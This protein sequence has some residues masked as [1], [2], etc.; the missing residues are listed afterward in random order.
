MAVELVTLDNFK[1]LFEHF[2]KT[3]YQAKKVDAITASI[4]EKCEKL[5]AKDY[6]FSIINN[7]NGE[8]CNTYPSRIIFLEGEKGNASDDSLKKPDDENNNINEAAR[9]RERV[10][11]SRV[12]RC[13]TRFPVPVILI[14]GKFICRSSTLACG[15]EIYPRM[16]YDYLFP[17]DTT[18]ADRENKNMVD[19][20]EEIEDS[21]VAADPIEIDQDPNDEE[22]KVGEYRTHDVLLLRELSI[23][24]ICDLMMEDRKVKLAMYVTSSEKADRRNRYKEFAVLSMPYPGCEFFQKFRENDYH[25]EKMKF[26]WSQSYIKRRL[27]LPCDYSAAVEIEWGKYKEWD[28]NTLTQNYMKVLIKCITEG[29]SS[30]LVHC[31]SGWDRTPLFISLLRMSLW[32]DG[33]VHHSLSPLEMV[34]LTVGYDWFLFGHQLGCRLSKREEIMKYCFYYLKP[35]ISLMNNEI[36]NGAKRPNSPMELEENPDVTLQSNNVIY[37]GS[38]GLK[39]PDALWS[40]IPEDHVMEHTLPQKNRPASSAEKQESALK[41]VDSSEDLSQIRCNTPTTPTHG[42]EDA[43]QFPVIPPDLQSTSPLAVP[44]GSRRRT[45]SSSSDLSYLFISETGSIPPTRSPPPE[46]NL[47]FRSEESRKD[48]LNEVRTIFLKMYFAFVD[49]RFKSGSGTGIMGF[50][51]QYAEKVGIRTPKP[52]T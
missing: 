4:Q 3:S 34:Y 22:S 1:E 24:R 49:V 30:L 43:A 40:P 52:P 42:K 14:D 45:E 23:T 36:S 11:K 37:G 26:D 51:N 10:A 16:S 17:D 39:N 27:D 18:D 25:G 28:L 41:S 29:T 33:K 6:K 31:I 50:I 12:A 20:Y 2:T 48:K 35:L 8:L 19:E 44:S 15:K 38:D 32:A 5:F 9:Y 7:A 13:R 46:L 47:S 21:T